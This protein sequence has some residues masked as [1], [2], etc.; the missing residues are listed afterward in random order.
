MVSDQESRD[1]IE[2][3]NAI[4][5]PEAGIGLAGQDI[6]TLLDVL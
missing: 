4:L 6:K 1:I 3:Y 2:L 5:K